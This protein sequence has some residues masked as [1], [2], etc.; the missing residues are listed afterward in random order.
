[1][2]KM[3]NGL[4]KVSSF[5]YDREI[6]YSLDINTPWIND[7]LISLENDQILDKERPTTKGFL[8]I[9]L[10]FKRIKDPTLF[11]CIILKGNLSSLYYCSC[12]RCLELTHR[13][14]DIDLNCCFIS[15]EFEESELIDDEGKI[16]TENEDLEVFFYQKGVLNLKEYLQEHINMSVDPLPLHDENCKG[17]CPECG[18][19]LNLSEC[20]HVNR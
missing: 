12:I 15:S 9:N 18:T 11:D 13:N 19:N 2:E 5:I 7:L 20:P 3:A 16:L 1:M 17:L 14:I 10:T 6:D 4:I 8:N